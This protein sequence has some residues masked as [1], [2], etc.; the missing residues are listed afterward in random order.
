MRLGSWVGGVIFVALLCSGCATRP[1]FRSISQADRAGTQVI[2]AT[3]R[4]ASSYSSANSRSLRQ[5]GSESGLLPGLIMGAA[6]S[7]VEG[8]GVPWVDSIRSRS[9]LDEADLLTANIQERV[10]KLAA[11]N[12]ETSA[13]P[14]LEVTSKEAGIAE[15]QRGG[16]SGPVGRVH[17]RLRNSANKELWSAEASSTSTQLRRREDYDT[18]PALY[19]E[20]FRQVAEDLARQLIDGPIR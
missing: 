12:T 7:S 18:N 2:N 11:P 8:K 13:G 20:D 3:P 4:A 19:A 16:Y 10:Q 1:P 6:A 5:S 17:A 9:G 15:L 14:V